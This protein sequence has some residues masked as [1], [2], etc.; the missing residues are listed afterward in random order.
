MSYYD[1]DDPDRGD[2]DWDGDGGFHD[3][4]FRDPGGKS[5]LRAGRRIYPCPTCGTKNALTAADVARSYQCD[6]CADRAEGT[7]FGADY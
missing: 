2:R 4:P 1:Y 6:A 7:Y 3:A 5:A